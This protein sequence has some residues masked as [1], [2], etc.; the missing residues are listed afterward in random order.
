VSIISSV[1]REWFELSD[2]FINALERQRQLELEKIEV[3]II[4]G[5]GDDRLARY[6][7]AKQES[8]DGPLQLEL[9]S[10]EKC[11]R[12]AALNHGIKRSSSE[13]LLFLADDFIATSFLV[14]E[15]LQLHLHRPEEHV[16]GIG[17]GIFPPEWEL[18]PYMRWLDYDGGLFGVSFVGDDAEP[19]PPGFFYGANTSIKRSFL[20]RSG[21]FDEDFPYDCGDDS[22]L[23]VRLAKLGLQ[24]VFLP[25]AVAH[26][27]HEQ[28]LEDG[29]IRGRMGGESAA[30][31]DL[32]IGG[33]SRLRAGLDR[34]S[35]IRFRRP[36]NQKAY[37]KTVIHQEFCHA[38][39]EAALSLLAK[40]K[41]K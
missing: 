41:A 35:K 9:F 4:D 6:I 16:V 24:T 38:Y 23:G 12:G 27:W 40:A 19:P 31:L 1:E 7:A 10:V 3:L 5:F 22:E 20:E 33:I 11:G 15:H 34:N 21:L 18:S 2:R 37:W 36:K 30:I 29:R 13:L 28:G 32:K 14:E 17:P 39:R 26:H 8:Y 25:A